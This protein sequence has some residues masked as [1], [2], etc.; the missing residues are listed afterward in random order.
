MALHLQYLF[1]LQQ[2]VVLNFNQER[3]SCPF[4]TYIWCVC[5]CVC[6]C[7]YPYFVKASSTRI[8]FLGI[9]KFTDQRSCVVDIILG[10]SAKFL[11][12]TSAVI[13]LK[14]NGMIYAAA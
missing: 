14:E 11:Q 7:V 12:L 6:M 10:T 4:I 1:G 13:N 2:H 9:I 3:Y 5:V 8:D